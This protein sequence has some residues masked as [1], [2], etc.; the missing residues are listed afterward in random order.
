[1]TPFQLLFGRSPR[2]TLDVWVP[3]M[4]DTDATVGL[5]NFI[6]NRRHNM[7]EVAEALKKLH[8]DKEV[9]R[10]R[11]NAGIS[12]PSAEVNV[13]K[14]DIVL[15]RESDSALFR[16]G[17]RSKLVHEKLTD[18]WTVTKIVFKGLS[19][20]I[21]MDGRKKRSRSV[22]VASLK[23]FYRHSSDLRHPIG[24]EFAQIA[25]GADLGLKGDSV[26]SAPMYTLTDRRKIES[27]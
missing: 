1:M 26:V 14:G 17:M 2:T 22:S 6:E 23:P 16:Q 24:D 5:S 8:E 11:H 13:A 4:D 21:E 19:A 25:W 18:S 10:Q 7:Q 9:A 3:Q 27:D 20:V 15:A 12:R